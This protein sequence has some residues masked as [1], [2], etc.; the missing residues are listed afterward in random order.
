MHRCLGVDSALRRVEKERPEILVCR[1]VCS[2]A[3][4]LCER[5]Y[6]SRVACAVEDFGVRVLVTDVEE[7][8][9]RLRLRDHPALSRRLA[10]RKVVLHCQEASELASLLESLRG[11]VVVGGDVLGGPPSAARVGEAAVAISKEGGRREA[12]PCVSEE[13]TCLIL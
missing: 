2:V 12:A 13:S 11:G 5:E 7:G 9:A 6:W 1:G 3:S 4:W 8:S 10:R